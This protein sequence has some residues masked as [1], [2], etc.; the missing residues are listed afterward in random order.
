MWTIEPWSS[1]L[2]GSAGIG[3][4]GDDHAVDLGTHFDHLFRLHGARN[5]KRL[6]RVA[7]MGLCGSCGFCG[8]PRRFDLRRRR[9]LGAA[10]RP[11]CARRNTPR[12]TPRHRPP[13]RRQGGNS[14]NRLHEI[15]S[16][17]Q[18][19]SYC[20]SIHVRRAI[21]AGNADSS[22]HE[23]ATILHPGHLATFRLGGTKVSRRDDGLSNQSVRLL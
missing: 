20:F 6:G 21:L 5:D 11:F 3:S 15:T 17:A 2:L 18:T 13:Q 8:V 23:S 7:V 16:T 4:H 12:R 14:K 1:S 22:N 19:T 9:R 10:S